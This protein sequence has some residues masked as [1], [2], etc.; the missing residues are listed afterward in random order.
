MDRARGPR[1]GLRSVCSRGETGERA[2]VAGRPKGKGARPCGF[3]AE[4][5]GLGLGRCG[6]KRVGA[7]LGCWVWIESGLGFWVSFLFYFLSLF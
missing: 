1:S 5:P 7:G 6:E 2:R 3:G 4:S